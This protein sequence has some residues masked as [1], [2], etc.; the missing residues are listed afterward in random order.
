M[1][2]YVNAAKSNFRILRTGAVCVSAEQ[3]V[4]ARLLL[5][6]EDPVTGGPYYICSY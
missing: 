3:N 5:R 4:H 1:K 2:Q 6:C